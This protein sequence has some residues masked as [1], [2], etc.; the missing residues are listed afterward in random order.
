MVSNGARPVTTLEKVHSN[1]LRSS[2]I[3]AASFTRRRGFLGT[4]WA[5]RNVR[6]VRAH[7]FEVTT[8]LKSILERK[9]E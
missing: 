3:E 2:I 6:Y 9:E 8:V 1:I 5:A 4:F 7:F